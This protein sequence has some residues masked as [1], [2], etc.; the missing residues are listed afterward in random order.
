MEV[1][2]QFKA[3]IDALKAHKTPEQAGIVTLGA[4][5]ATKD[6]QVKTFLGKAQSL[7]G[8]AYKSAKAKS[9]ENMKALE[10]QAKAAGTSDEGYK[11]RAQIKA[12]Q[13][14]RLVAAIG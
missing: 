1:D 3:Q 8:Q 6:Q 13:A 5:Q 7:M 11:L 14:E 10:A 2:P 12:Y 4:D 9:N